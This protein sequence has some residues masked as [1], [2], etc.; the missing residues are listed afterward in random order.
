MIP[1][2]PIYSINPMTLYNQIEIIDE[3]A[4]SLES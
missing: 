2:L 4:I 1:I 3:I